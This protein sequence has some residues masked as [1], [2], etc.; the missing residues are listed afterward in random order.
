MRDQCLVSS[1]QS[2]PHPSVVHKKLDESKAESLSSSF[3][4]KHRNA[5][6]C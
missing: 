3:K 1:V 2:A 5:T 4:F 6:D